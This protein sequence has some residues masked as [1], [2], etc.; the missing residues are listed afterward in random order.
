MKN[1]L[2]TGSFG[3]LGCIMVVVIILTACSH[4]TFVV[5]SNEAY[6][7]EADAM[8]A[9]G[10][11]KVQE[12]QT[13]AVRA[14]IA[15]DNTDLQQVRN[16]RSKQDASNEHV[17]VQ[18]L[19]PNLRLYSPRNTSSKP[20]PLLLYLHGGGWCFGSIMSCSRFCTELCTNSDIMVAALDYRLA[21]EYPFPCAL[22]DCTEALQFL[23][24]EATRLG[25]NPKLISL[26]G[27]SSGGNLAIVTALQSNKAVHSLLLFYPVTNICPP[28]RASWQTYSEGYGCDA[29]IMEAFADAYVPTTKRSNPLVSPLLLPDTEISRLPRTLLVAAQRDVLYDQG[30]QF[31]E[32]MRRQHVPAKHVTLVGSI[33]LFITVPGQDEAFWHSVKLAKEFLTSL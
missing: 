14:A 9:S 31:V 21:P 32:R 7:T 27:D 20:R 18:Q 22:E 10:R 16:G 1:I 5:S 4:R 11:L 3:F 2:I 28:Y 24:R 6:R 17:I 15:G 33:H 25:I 29:Q 23:V 8:I 30:K 12:A 19:S 13:N 26:G